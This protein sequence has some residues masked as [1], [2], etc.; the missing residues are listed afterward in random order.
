[1]EHRTN[2]TGYHRI[3]SAYDSVCCL[4]GTHG[5]LL[6]KE[7]AVCEECLEYVKTLD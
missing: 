3:D 2:R 6:F 1:M 5:G 4:C 7:A